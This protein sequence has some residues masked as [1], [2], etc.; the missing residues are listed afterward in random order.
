[1]L[2]GN[3]LDEMSISCQDGN[4]DACL[5][6][7]KIF[8]AKIPNT[9]LVEPKTNKIYIEKIAYFYK[10]AC[11][12]GNAEGCRY[13]AMHYALDPLRDPKKDSEFYFEKACNMGDFTSC[14]LL[15]M[16][17]KKDKK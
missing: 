1:M 17:P 4:A 6:A 12:L 14:T 10:N 15:R 8:S 7:G 13:Y 11:K 3:I 9:K 2:Q 16:M 5:H